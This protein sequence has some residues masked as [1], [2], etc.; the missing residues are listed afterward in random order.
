MRRFRRHLWFSGLLLIIVSASPAY[1]DAGVPMIF[2]TFPGMLIALIPVVGIESYVLKHALG[3][4]I[5]RPIK[6]S[7]ITNSVSTIIGI[8]LTW[9]LLVVA[10]MVT[11]GGRAYG[12]DT[13]FQKFLS[14]TWQ[15]P[16]LIPYE[17]QLYWMIPA[18]TLVLLI[19][20]FFV[21]WFIEH[22]V[23]KRI[24]MEISSVRVNRSIFRAN[25]ISYTLL[26]L[27]VLGIWATANPR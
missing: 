16:W 23:A 15:A 21:S 5:S 4:T 27:F 2:V 9:L 20:F 24:L 13:V 22:Q 14:V 11:G 3:L 10:Q 12:I 18:A 19:P 17:S 26:A 6:T 25:L 8:P 7:A 1:A